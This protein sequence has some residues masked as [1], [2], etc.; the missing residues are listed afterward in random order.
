MTR[1]LI[2]C[3]VVIGVA[4]ASRADDFQTEKAKNWHQLRGPEATGV[5]PLGNPPTEWSGT[6]NIKWKVEI[7]GRGSASP[8]VWGDRIFILTAIKTERT[9][10]DKAAAAGQKVSPFRLAVDTKTLLAQRDQRSEENERDG[11]RPRDGERRG[12]GDFERGRGFG[13]RFGGGQP[14]TNFHQF[15]VLCLDRKTGDVIWQRTANE[16]IPHEGHHQTGSFAS[17]SPTTDGKKLYASFG[18]RGIYCFDLDGNPLWDKD[19]GDLKTRMS[20]GEGSSPVL[21]GDT[22]VVMWDQ[23]EGSA[24]V[25]LDAN[26]GKQKWRVPREEVTTWSTP[27]IVEAAGRTQV[28]AS[29]T[30]R[31][32]SYDLSNGELIWECGGLGSNPI[33]CPVVYENLAIV[34]TGHRDPAGVAVPLDAQGDVTGTDKIAWQVDEITPYVSS[35]LLY[36]D[37]IYFVKSRN[38]ILSSLAAKTGEP[39]IRQKRL[40][41]MDSVYASPVGANGRIYF[42]SREGVTNVL[43]QGPEFEVLATNKLDETIDASPAIVGNEM[44]I[45]GE[46]HLYCISE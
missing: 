18:S 37:T 28:I 9:A 16:I 7:P 11:G 33:A 6:K 17:G 27:L 14:P 21:H 22:L 42:C 26:T 32:R 45:R 1:P 5:A 38:A 20:F 36:D 8:I 19:L 41:E 44:F 30:N 29:G 13:G 12:R 3:V 34:M 46:K 25:A 43:K 15:V 24:I 31:V 10:D 4:T 40:P 35:P 23:E 39:I 2:L